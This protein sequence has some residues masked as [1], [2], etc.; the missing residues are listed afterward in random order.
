MQLHDEA[1]V[2]EYTKAGYWGHES[3][4]QLLAEHADRRPDRLAVVDPANLHALA[5]VEPRELSWSELAAYVDAMAQQ[6]A[7]AGVG[8]EHVVGVQL[9]N[10]VALT[11][12]LLAVTRIGAV[13]MP[14]AVQLGRHEIAQAAAAAQMRAFV[15]AVR[16][17]ERELLADFLG[18]RE[19]LPSVHVVLGLGTE[20]PD[21]VV[22]LTGERAELPGELPG[23]N[24]CVTICLTSGTESAP[25]GV[26]RCMND[27]RPMALGSVDAADLGPDDVLLNPFPMVNMAGIAGMFLPWLLTGCTLIHHHPFD[28]QVFFGQIGRYA[29]TY[30]VAP[31]ALLMMVLARDDLPPQL[32][33]SLKVIGSGSAPLAPAMT[34]GWADRFGIEVINAFGSNEGV[35]LAGD[36]ATVPDRTDRARLF[37]RFGSPDHHWPNRASHGMQ[38]RLVDP[39][40]GVVEAPGVPGE[41]RVKGPGVFAGYLPGTGGDPFDEEGYYRTGDVFEYVTDERGDPR[42]L[43]YVD[44]MKDIV[45]RGGQNISAAEV[46]GLLAGHPEIA[47]AAVVGIPDD[48][49]GER[50]CA[51][52][53]VRGE[54]L[55]VQDVAPYLLERG[56]ATF[57]IPE[58]VEVVDALPRNPVGK[59]LKRELRESLGDA[60]VSR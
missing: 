27:W 16:F 46:E 22:P 47:E 28:P 8:R 33:A 2:E 32:F 41:L 44:R 29:V 60:E 59:I 24:D 42:Y 35:C 13:A 21:G 26:Q 34:N 50:A 37:P 9:P 58:R 7:A 38:T 14:F 51:F 1:T 49:M 11:A 54:P 20:L 17:G 40:G 52:L 48:V 25:K 30:T 36:P 19:E 43:R 3:W 55:D 15:G 39:A 57:K 6:L 45:V 4:H 31:P 53:V 56:V 18:Y 23:L 12:A 5:G 10:G